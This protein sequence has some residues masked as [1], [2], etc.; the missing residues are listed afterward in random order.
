MRPDARE[1]RF[2]TVE[3]VVLYPDELELGFYTVHIVA[4]PLTVPSVRAAVVIVGPIEPQP[5][6]CPSFPANDTCENGKVGLHCQISCI[7]L[8]NNP[9][10]VTIPPLSVE[11]F[12]LDGRRND[13][14]N[15]I[16]AFSHQEPGS[17]SVLA[18]IDGQPTT[19][20]RYSQHWKYEGVTWSLLVPA[21][22][23]AQISYVGL[24]LVNV[25]PSPS[26]VT[27][28]IDFQNLESP[29]ESDPPG[30]SKDYYLPMVV[31]YILVAMLLPIVI[32]LIFCLY[33]SRRRAN[34]SPLS[35]P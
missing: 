25:G 35:I 34:R 24:A 15:I 12:H 33:I 21:R 28:S 6:E 10:K 2:S 31:G 17:F 14:R 32:V 26:L 8:G 5:S 29:S 1:E 20:G 3:K 23:A 22:T 4:H 30:A 7:V 11:Y 13:N 27:A 19:L 18:E 16:V 9:Q